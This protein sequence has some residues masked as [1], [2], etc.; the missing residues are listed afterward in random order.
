MNSSDVTELVNAQFVKYWHCQDTP[1]VLRGA[2]ARECL[3]EHPHERTACGWR[4]QAS[5]TETQ[6]ALFLRRIIMATKGE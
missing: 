1:Y 2:G 4:Y 6:Y 3:P 5:M